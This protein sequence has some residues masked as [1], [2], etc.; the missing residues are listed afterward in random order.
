MRIQSVSSEYI[1]WPHSF[2]LVL[3]AAITI[4]SIQFKP[5]QFLFSTHSIQGGKIK[6]KI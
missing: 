3:L 1:R 4:Y 5:L 2:Q 6:M